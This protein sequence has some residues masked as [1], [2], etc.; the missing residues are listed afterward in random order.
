MKN[1]S[2][3]NVDLGG[4]EIGDIGI[5]AMLA[6]VNKWQNV[7]KLTFHLDYC[8][9]T[10]VGAVMLRN[11]LPHANI[12]FQGNPQISKENLKLSCPNWAKVS[13]KQRSQNG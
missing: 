11:Q 8:N 4:N 12:Y 6:N 10:D 1:P 3:T 9:I 7:T 2:I 13:L 5:C